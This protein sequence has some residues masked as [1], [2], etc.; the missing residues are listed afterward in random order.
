MLESATGCVESCPPCT[1]P[2]GAGPQTL[3]DTGS[4]PLGS[5]A[6]LSGTLLPPSGLGDMSGPLSTEQTLQAL[7]PGQLLWLRVANT[8]KCLS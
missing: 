2:N 7:P 3:G 1:W 8:I 4:S 5:S 6:G